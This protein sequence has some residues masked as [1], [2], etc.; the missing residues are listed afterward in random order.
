MKKEAALFFPSSSFDSA[1]LLEKVRRLPTWETAR[2]C[3][4]VPP[5]RAVFTP[6][7]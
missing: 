4:D 3:Q 1:L 2:P 5:G 6:P 7:V